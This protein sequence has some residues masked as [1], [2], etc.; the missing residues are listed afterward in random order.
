MT[1]TRAPVAWHCRG[2]S[3]HRITSMTEPKKRKA[4]GH[5][6]GSIHQRKDGRWAGTI[7]LGT[8]ANGK[9][10]RRTVYGVTKREVTE[11][12]TKM[13]NQRLDGSL[14]ARERLTVGT[15]VDRWMTNWTGNLRDNS[16]RRYQECVD[17]FIKPALG[18]VDLVKLRPS[19]VRQ[20]L[21]D[22]ETK[23]L[24]PRQRLYVFQTI[25]RALNVAVKLELV[26]RNV[27][28]SVDAP[29]V[30]RRPIEAL[31]PDQ[32]NAILELVAGTRWEALFMLA[33]S[34]GMRQGE[35]F[36]L[37][38]D[39]IDFSR[40]V[41]A[42]RHSLEEVNSR[43]T[44]KE[45]KSDSGRRSIRL[46]PADISALKEHRQWLGTVAFGPW[47]F[48]DAD[49][50]LLRKSNFLRKV[51][52]PIREALN[53]KGVRFHDMR[54]SAA[55]FMLRAGIHPKIAQTR[56]GHS[57]IKLTMDTYSHLMPDAQEEAAGAFHQSRGDGKSTNGCT[58]A[59]KLPGIDKKKT[60]ET[61]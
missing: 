46:D 21:D 13:Q 32:A 3:S 48:P 36:A 15:L 27:T 55:S 25:R 22:L 52:E 34:T 58:T 59:V 49:G 41:I 24:G 5:G 18:T 38:W 30:R 10:H 29:K 53:L 43:L 4:R 54:H 8:D 7:S 14:V 44:I 19:H 47:V 28:K 20:M 40:G 9:R 1:L 57:T 56:L 50:K 2:F 39:D 6:E 60:A 17:R 11:Q 16:R 42:V 61:A 35:L 37:A 23:G 26:V 12:L 45:P 31:T 51:W 33:L